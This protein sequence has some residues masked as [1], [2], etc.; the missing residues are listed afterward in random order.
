MMKPVRLAKPILS[1]QGSLPAHFQPNQVDMQK[2]FIEFRYLAGVIG[3]KRHQVLL[4]LP[5][6]RAIAGDTRESFHTQTS[7]RYPSQQRY[8]KRSG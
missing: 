5:E 2:Q 1:S 8:S 7:P 6:T 3:H 4:Y